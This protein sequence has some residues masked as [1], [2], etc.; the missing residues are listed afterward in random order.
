MKKAKTFSIISGVIAAGAA[1]FAAASYSLTKTLVRV[2]LDRNAPKTSERSRNRLSGTVP[3]NELFELVKT[4][5]QELESEVCETVSLTSFDGEQLVGHLFRHKNAQRII[6]AMHGWRSSWT[7]DFGIISEF[8]HNN[9][10]TVLYAEQRGQN[11]SGGDYIGFGMIERHDCLSWINWVNDNLGDELPIYLAGLSMGAS[12]V[13]MAA[14]AVLPDN[15]CGVIADCGYTSPYA[16]WKYIAQKNLHL[17]YGLMGAFANSI[18]KK[19]LNM[20]ANAYSTIDAMKSS[21]VPVLFIHGSD[22]RFVPVEMTYEN[23]KACTAPKR[24]LIVPGAGHC[25]SYVVD[26]D[27]Y[28]D[29]ITSFWQD[30]DKK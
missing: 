8:W 11:N 20:D 22:D 23:Y 2:A 15:V 25:M 13:L 17:S 26:K 18:C 19:K 4:A 9:N 14:G 24:L 21:P 28:E 16:I 7:T 6:I 30:F 10:C 1:I 29:A 12:T 5:A 27:S 3:N